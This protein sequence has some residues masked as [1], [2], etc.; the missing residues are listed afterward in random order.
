MK[1]GRASP[2]R[3]L[4][5]FC[6]VARPGLMGSASALCR[7]DLGAVARPC[8][9]GFVRAEVWWSPARSS[10]PGLPSIPDVP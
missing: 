4:H 6:S 2:T 3:N 7:P 9:L 10:K 8:C 1:P 5:H